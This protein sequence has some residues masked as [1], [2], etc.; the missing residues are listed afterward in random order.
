MDDIVGDL[1]SLIVNSLL[2][3][4][5]KKSFGYVREAIGY[6][7]VTHLLAFWSFILAAST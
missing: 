5:L 3:A 4:V 6:R 7:S 1:D 2:L